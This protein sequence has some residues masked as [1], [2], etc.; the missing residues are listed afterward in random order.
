MMLYSERPDVLKQAIER[1]KSTPIEKLDAE[2]RSLIIGTM[3]RHGDDKNV[4]DALLELHQK[5]SSADLQQDIASGLTSTKN[6]D[7]IQRLLEL[8][9]D[10]K[11]VRPQD[12]LHWFIWL[13]RNRDGRAPAW[14]W[15]RENWTWVEKTYGGDK[16]YDY[17]PRF[18]GNTLMTRQELDEYKT[19]FTPMLSNP[20][21]ERVIT[22]GISDIQGRIELLERDTEAVRNAFN[23]LELS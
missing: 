5:T 20:S 23:K 4:F 11:V 6:I 17:F 13:I 3:I 1:Y 14:K 16:S 18:A 12:S 7:E 19:F 15:L 2:L 8:L 22:I 21:L 9:K 10:D